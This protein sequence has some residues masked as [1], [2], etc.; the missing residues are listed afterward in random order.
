[1]R[2]KFINYLL[3]AALCSLINTSAYA[4]DHNQAQ[5]SVYKLTRPFK[6]GGT[7][8]FWSLALSDTEFRYDTPEHNNILIH[9][10]KPLHAAGMKLGFLRVYATKTIQKKQRVIIVV[11]DNPE[12]C[13]DG[14]SDENHGYDAI[15]IFPTKIFS[16][17]CD[18]TDKNEKK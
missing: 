2:C 4:N 8:P 6:C 13:T 18:M 12:G 9:P 11:K 15:I 17:C 1:M 14:M 3:I 7:E 16:G 5:Q 10:V